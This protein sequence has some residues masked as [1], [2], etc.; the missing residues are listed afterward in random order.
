MGNETL[1]IAQSLVHELGL[2]VI[3][4]DHPAETMQNDPRRI[5]KVP[6]SSWKRW[7]TV[8][9]TDDNLVYWFGNAHIR[10]IGI[11]TGAVSGV[12]VIDC[13]SPPA[14]KWADTHLPATPWRVRTGK[15]EHR[16]YRHPGRPVR[17]KT[18]VRTGDPAVQIDVRADGGYVVAPGSVHQN[19]TRY[20][21]M[22][23]RPDS[24]GQL[25]MFDP[26]WLDTSPIPGSQQA[27]MARDDILRRARAYLDVTPSAIE[28][29][30]GDVHTF[31]VCCR[32]VRGFCLSDSDALLALGEWN[33]RCLPPWSE[34]E[35][36]AKIAGAR[37][38]GDEPLGGRLDNRPERGEF[39]SPADLKD[40][41]PP[42]EVG[43]A[44]FFSR[45]VAGR[46]LFDHL[47]Q[48]WFRFQTHHWRPD[49]T[50]QIVQT[51][52]AAMRLRQEIALALPASEERT[53]RLKHA[54]AGEAEGRIR[55]LLEL[56]STHPQLAIEGTEWDRD[57]SLLGVA[58]GVVDLRTGILR[59]GTPQDHVTRIAP[60]AYDPAAA[61]P[62]W[63]RFILE[64]CD[65]QPELADFLQR[66]IG[67]SLTGETSEQCFWLFYGL[68]SNGKSTLLETLTQHVIPE[69][70]WTMAFPVA[71][72]AESMSE[73][74]RAE[75]V[76]RRIVVAKE[77]EH[78]KRLNTE[79]IKSLTGG[80]TVNARHPYGRPF[81]F[82][83][84]A[85]FYL[86]CNHKPIIRDESHGMWRRVRLIPFVRTF[87]VDPTFADKLAAEAAGI[88]A[89]CVRGCLAWQRQ[90]LMAPAIVTGATGKYERDSDTLASFIDACCI[91]APGV[92]ARAGALFDAYTRWC[93]DQRM[94]ETDRLNR[95]TFGER[96]KRTFQA[97][98][99][100][101]VTYTGLGL[102]RE[103]EE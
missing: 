51:A 64:V 101:H 41:H 9:P 59:D 23:S 40:D 50:K 58:N 53:R 74:Q 43:D 66:S 73:Y 18:R 84:A 28:G 86:A 46:V 44:E 22:G 83:P 68:G 54:I 12:V 16:G 82:V 29:Q 5:G 99:G 24:I 3:P 35:L 6:I 8:K 96:V 76:G 67:Y 97:I 61:C 81:T 69:H 13:D 30:G 38:Y 45:F 47:R 71:T 60:V 42:T 78:A 4:L 63:N 103:D 14:V 89:W 21:W 34:Q 36:E 72:W 49:R 90:G 11:V 2:S 77:S 37:K 80:D 100:R 25:P 7:Q 48:Q 87:V 1:M 10:N 92:T 70:A 79:F 55:H 57:V 98:E 102:R 91:V 15:G 32:L 88:L 19:G 85:K 27:T 95:R 33:A 56:A 26:A 62:T 31:K 17:N 93:E 52:I 65:E 39:S 94:A 20:E 75:L